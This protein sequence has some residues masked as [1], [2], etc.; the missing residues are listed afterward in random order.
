MLSRRDSCR[1]CLMSIPGSNT[2]IAGLCHVQLRGLSKNCDRP[3]PWHHSKMKWS[4]F[5]HRRQLRARCLKTCRTWLQP[6]HTDHRLSEDIYKL[7]KQA[8]TL[9]PFFQVLAQYLLCRAGLDPMTD[10]AAG[11][12]SVLRGPVQEP[13]V[14]SPPGSEGGSPRRQSSAQGSEAHAA[15]T[16]A[17]AARQL[18][19]HPSPQVSPMN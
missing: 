10:L 8:Q 12:Q 14:R 17:D 9:H 11:L 5:N 19:T 1:D 3:I 6:K 15:A 7:D 2:G 18:R 16:S 4:I 13:T